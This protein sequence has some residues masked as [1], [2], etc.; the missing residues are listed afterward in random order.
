MSTNST[1]ITD[2][3]RD[4]IKITTFQEY[5]TDEYTDEYLK[6]IA[7]CPRCDS[8]IGSDK[9]A[10]VSGI[11]I[12]GTCYRIY[13]EAA[14]MFDMQFR[15]EL[16][17]NSVNSVKKKIGT[18]S[19]FMRKLK[20]SPKVEPYKSLNYGKLCYMCRA[21]VEPTSG[22]I[23]N[24]YYFDTLKEQVGLCLLCYRKFLT[25]ITN[26]FNEDKN[27]NASYE[28]NI[29]AVRELLEQMRCETANE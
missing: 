2:Y 7:T 11:I 4:A 26:H 25:A 17:H 9:A 23:E 16:W 18:Y 10:T 13:K 8:P 19:N 5:I 1:P 22:E 14:I 12:C 15:S 21:S 29:K 20:K 27:I 6:A 28:D 3:Y 24:I